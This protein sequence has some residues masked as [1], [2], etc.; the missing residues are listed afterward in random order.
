[1]SHGCLSF[2]P[3]SSALQ[4]PTDTLAKYLVPILEPLTIN[5]YSVKDSFNFTTKIVEQDS[6]NFMGSL[7]IDSLFA[8]IPLEE[9]IEICT[10]KLFKNSDIAHGLKKSEFKD[11]LFIFSNQRVAFHI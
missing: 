5:K 6:S 4:T 3:I 11:L 1:M 8:I 7:D 2:R 9:A 10:N